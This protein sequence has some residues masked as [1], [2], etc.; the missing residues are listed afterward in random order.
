MG[1]K[2]KIY[3][4]IFVKGGVMFVISTVL[5]PV[6]ILLILKFSFPVPV[7]VL[8]Y[9]MVSTVWL[10]PKVWLIFFAAVCGYFKLTKTQF[11]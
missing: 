7:P 6:S 8:Q 2:S 3:L 5:V 4:Q 11:F 1:I 9:S 10:V